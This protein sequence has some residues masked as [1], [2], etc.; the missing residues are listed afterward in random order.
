MT[1]YIDSAE[2]KCGQKFFRRSEKVGAVGCCDCGFRILW[3]PRIVLVGCGKEKVSYRT[4]AEN[5]YTSSYFEKKRQW[6]VGFG[7]EWRI[8]SAKHHLLDPHEKIEPYNISI[9]DLDIHA[10]WSWGHTV[11]DQL[12]EY[13]DDRRVEEIVVLAGKSYR[14]YVEDR[15]DEIADDLGIELVYPFEGTSGIGDQIGWLTTALKTGEPFPDDRQ[16][17]RRE[18]LRSQEQESIARWSA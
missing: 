11:A 12:D 13:L 3:N 17:D 7:G 6:A 8:L 2:C 4:L 9:D 5:L 15:L 10:K 14:Q 16:I 18:R 1:K